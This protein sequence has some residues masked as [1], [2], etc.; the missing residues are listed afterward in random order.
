MCIICKK[1]TASLMLLLFVVVFMLVFSFTF[2]NV[3]EASRHGYEGNI[4]WILNEWDKIAPKPGATWVENTTVRSWILEADKNYVTKTDPNQPYIGS[5]VI[6]TKA[7]KNGTMTLAG[8]I[9]EIND[10]SIT[11]E[12]LSPTTQ[13]PFKDIVEH[14]KILNS[15]SGYKFIGYIWPV[16]KNDYNQNPQK[17]PSPK[18]D[19]DP[20]YKGFRE[21]WYGT[22]ILKE[23]DKIAPAPGVNWTGPTYSWITGADIKGWKTSK[24]PAAAKV[25]ALIVRGDTV[26]DKSW[27]GIVREVTETGIV[28]EWGT[29]SLKSSTYAVAY[30]DLPNLF[31]EGYIYPELK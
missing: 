28:V 26:N 29:R 13:K 8:I 27:V 7:T 31:F 14:T 19:T 20:R 10:R 16:L 3:A 23:F 2:S 5:V 15:F 24:D 21:N 17:Y 18:I 11:I 25:G 30:A 4:G 12:Y 1:T 6:W 22:P 9:R